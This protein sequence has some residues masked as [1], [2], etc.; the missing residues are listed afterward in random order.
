M[1]GRSMLVFVLVAICCAFVSSTTAPTTIFVDAGVGKDS[2][3]SMGPSGRAVTLHSNENEFSLTANGNQVLKMTPLSKDSS[4]F[5]PAVTGGFSIGQ[6]TATNIYSDDF[7]IVNTDAPLQQW[8]IVHLDTFANDTNGWDVATGPALEIS[9]CGGVTMLGGP[10][11]TSNHVVSKT[12]ELPQH[13]EIQVTARVHFLDNWD[14]DTAFMK[15]STA[16]GEITAWTEQYTW[17]PQFFT[18]MCAKGNSACGKEEYP[19]RL[20]KL[21]SVSVPHQEPTLTIKFGTN[22]PDIVPPCEVSYGISGVMIEVR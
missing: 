7:E 14:D 22:I 2:T 4:A 11:K 1:Q 13:A 5:S 3:L 18:M 6:I 12:Y 20:S 9:K 15:L 10:C 8:L 17:C 21:V 19:D 16:G